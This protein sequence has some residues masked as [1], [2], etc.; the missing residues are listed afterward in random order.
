MQ[1]EKMAG[2]KGQKTCGGRSNLCSSV[3]HDYKVVFAAAAALRNR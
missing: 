2:V 3:K 1:L